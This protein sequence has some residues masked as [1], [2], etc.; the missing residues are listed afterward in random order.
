MRKVK[1][2]LEA[3]EICKDYQCD[4]TFRKQYYGTPEHV[5]VSLNAWT[6]IIGKDLVEAVNRLVDVYYTAPCNHEN[7]EWWEEHQNFYKPK[8]INA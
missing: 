4:I 8:Y 1:T 2:E 3:L 6:K 5:I 7:L